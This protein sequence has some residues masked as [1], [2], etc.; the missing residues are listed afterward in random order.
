MGRTEIRMRRTAQ[1]QHRSNLRQRARP[2][3]LRQQA[4]A[5]L[6]STRWGGPP[7]G[8]PEHDPQAL[9]AQAPAPS[10]AQPGA[11]TCLR[12]QQRPRDKHE[13]SREALAV[14]MQGAPTGGRGCRFR[15][16][17]RTCPTRRSPR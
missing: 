6:P 15:Q 2:L 7:A 17:W 5:S 3:A 9:A 8:G 16:T 4:R 14:R 10:T 11:V 12:S 13:G 1:P